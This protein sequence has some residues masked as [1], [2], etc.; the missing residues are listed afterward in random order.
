MQSSRLIHPD[1]ISIEKVYNFSLLIYTKNNSSP[2]L[3][4]YRLDDLELNVGCSTVFINYIAGYES[5]LDPMNET[6]GVYYLPEMWNRI[7]ENVTMYAEWP[8]CNPKSNEIVELT[9]NETNTTAIVEL[10]DTVNDTD[11]KPSLKLDVSSFSTLPY[12]N[13]KVRLTFKIRTQIS[14]QESRWSNMITLDLC[15][16][17]SARVLVYPYLSIDKFSVQFVEV[18]TP[19]TRFETNMFGTSHSGCPC[20]RALVM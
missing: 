12:T 17:Q 11:H 13:A 3:H 14:P 6:L 18:N 5:P 1:D 9:I 20:T 2:V 10:N 16:P 19:Y 15:H 7:I 4:K 8:Y